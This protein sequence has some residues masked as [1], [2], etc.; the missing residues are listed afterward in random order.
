MGASISGITSRASGGP[1]S[2]CGPHSPHAADAHDHC[3]QTPSLHRPASALARHAAHMHRACARKAS[4]AFPA[5]AQ[6]TQEATT[7]EKTCAAQL[8]GA[9]LDAVLAQGPAWEGLRASAQ[10]VWAGH[11]EDPQKVLNDSWP[12]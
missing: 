12:P 11:K 9:A 5:H 8:D 10:D 1:S 7:I 3:L 6:G 4:D 2:G